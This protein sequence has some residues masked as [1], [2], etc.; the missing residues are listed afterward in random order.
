MNP[1]I[2]GNEINVKTA[3]CALKVAKKIKITTSFPGCLSREGRGER[4]WKRDLLRVD[5]YCVTSSERNFCRYEGLPRNHGKRNSNPRLV[6]YRKEKYVE[7]F[8]TTKLSGFV[9]IFFNGRC[10][11]GYFCTSHCDICASLNT[12]FLK[13]KMLGKICFCISGG[14][15]H[16][17]STANEDKLSKILQYVC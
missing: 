14:I 1:Y 15:V 16:A 8:N 2:N 17:I 11:N 13:R 4:A 12:C 10:M 3:V 6:G 5:D 7:Q 9:T